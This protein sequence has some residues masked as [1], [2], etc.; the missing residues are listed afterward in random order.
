MHACTWT[1]SYV[2]IGPDGYLAYPPP[3]YA[4]ALV[5][6]CVYVNAR[7]CACMYVHA[8][9]SMSV[10]ALCVKYIILYP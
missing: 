5:S 10:C 4:R 3:S 1:D 9:M 2:T 7:M 6:A 8:R